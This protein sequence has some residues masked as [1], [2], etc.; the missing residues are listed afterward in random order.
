MPHSRFS[1]EEIA[2]RGEQL[3]EKKIRKQVE[4]EENIGKVE[5]RLLIDHNNIAA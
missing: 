1:S 5:R 4:S 3:Y 2:R